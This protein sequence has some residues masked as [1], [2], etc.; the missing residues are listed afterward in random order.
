MK[1][2]EIIVTKGANGEIKNMP[3]SFC[4]K[5]PHMKTKL[6]DILHEQRSLSWLIMLKNWRFNL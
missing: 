1:K 2:K 5:M 4:E 6:N 3:Y